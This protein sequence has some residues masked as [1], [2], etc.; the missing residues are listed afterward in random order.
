M[1]VINMRMAPTFTAAIRLTKAT[2]FAAALMSFA[3]AAV[4]GDSI[5]K[6]G[7]LLM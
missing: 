7:L 6:K 4:A 2:A 1:N 5:E 3:P